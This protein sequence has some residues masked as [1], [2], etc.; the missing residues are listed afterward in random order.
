M[1]EEEGERGELKAKDNR[2]RGKGREKKKEERGVKRRE[3]LYLY[4]K[5]AT[6]ALQW[7]IFVILFVSQSDLCIS[8]CLHSYACK[9]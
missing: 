6:F 5:N 9:R 1:R 3:L 7:S 2:G 4:I 8:F